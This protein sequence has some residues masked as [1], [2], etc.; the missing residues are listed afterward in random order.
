M[1]VDK[2]VYLM[3]GVLLLKFLLIWEISKY[4][5]QS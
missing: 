3:F 2:Y 5:V 1:D 4:A